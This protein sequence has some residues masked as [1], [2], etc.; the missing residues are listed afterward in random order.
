MVLEGH[1]SAN[2][3][4][5]D[6]IGIRHLQYR[7]E[8][9]GCADCRSGSVALGLVTERVLVEEVAM[10]ASGSAYRGRPLEQDSR[11]YP[12]CA[13]DAEGDEGGAESVDEFAGC[14]VAAFGGEDRGGD[15]D[16]EHGADL[17]EGVAD[18]GRNRG[19]VWADGTHDSGRH[20]WE[21]DGDSGA[22]DKQRAHKVRYPLVS[23]TSARSAE[24]GRSEAE[25][26][27]HQRPLAD[28][29]GESAGDG[30]EAVPS[31]SRAAVAGRLRAGCSAAPAAG[32]AR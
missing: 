29:V 6:T 28:P 14:A 3:W 12:D 21:R 7:S 32:I 20:G 25:A 1:P 18:A 8:V 17:A 11:E 5:Y 4:P 2:W 10:S 24:A 23:V 30:G 26:E 9:D 15:R 13:Q 16:A 22:G 27:H 31:Q 19:L